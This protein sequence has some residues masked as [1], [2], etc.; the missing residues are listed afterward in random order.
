M[1][2]VILHYPIINSEDGI[3]ILFSTDNMD[4]IHNEMKVYKIVVNKKE[5]IKIP[6]G[7]IYTDKDNKKSNK[8]LIKDLTEETPIVLVNPFSEENLKVVESEDKEK[9]YKIADLGL[10]FKSSK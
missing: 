9:L 10:A 2:Y 7:G 1:C 6:I 4:Q 8:K 3:D 5:L